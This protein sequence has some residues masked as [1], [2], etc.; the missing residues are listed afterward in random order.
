VRRGRVVFGGATANSLWG[1]VNAGGADA[2]VTVVS[3][4]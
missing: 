2:T 3:T 1:Y 4:W